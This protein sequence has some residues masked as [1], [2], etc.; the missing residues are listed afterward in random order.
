MGT[1]KTILEN[2]L[3]PDFIGLGAQKAG[4]SWLYACLYEHPELCLPFK[5]IHYFS[6]EHHYAKGI[7]WYERHFESCSQG[8]L[9]GEFS[10]SYLYSPDT[11]RRIYEYHPTVK[12]IVCLRDPVSRAFSNYQNDIKAGQVSPNVSFGESLKSHPEYLEQGLYSQQLSRY[13]EHFDRKQL[14]IMVYEDSRQNPLEFVR[15][16]FRFLG[17]APN[18]VPVM[19]TRRIN[20]AHVPRCLALERMMQWTS[21]GLRKA[22]L[23]TLLWWIKQKG[24][25][26]VLYRL[27][28]KS[29]PPGGL[30]QEQ[31]TQFLEYFRADIQELESLLG[32][33]LE[34][35]RV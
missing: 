10:T 18:F 28:T 4:T 23:G 33:E 12:M 32:R 14:L 22:G 6:R 17:V 35:W 20:V 9:K 16:I 21:A 31:R 29:K 7:E 25:Q 24:F 15:T 8:L 26:D 30:S 11:A 1:E 2:G 5:E 27:N 34:P 19:L 3:K 13:L